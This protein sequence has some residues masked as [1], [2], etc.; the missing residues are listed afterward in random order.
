MKSRA[1]HV[2][3]KKSTKGREEEINCNLNSKSKKIFYVT[4]NYNLMR[5]DFFFFYSS[6]QLNVKTWRGNVLNMFFQPQLSFTQV[7]N[8]RN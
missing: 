3:K 5:T 2:N 4:S 1:S 6:S 7:E 8:V